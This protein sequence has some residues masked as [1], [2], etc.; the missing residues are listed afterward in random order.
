MDT[1]NNYTLL[2]LRAYD[3]LY[4]MDIFPSGFQPAKPFY[5]TS[6]PLYL[7]TGKR[8]YCNYQL[9]KIL[10]VPNSTMRETYLAPLFFFSCLLNQA[11]LHFQ[12]LVL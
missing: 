7:M 12:I 2:F 8:S 1:Q 10:L 3:I 6:H 4:N 9:K 5:L 11:F